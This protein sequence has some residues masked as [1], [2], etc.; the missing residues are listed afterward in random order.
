MKKDIAIGRDLWLVEGSIRWAIY[1]LNTGLIIQITADA[2]LFLS[3][4]IDAKGSF[5]EKREFIKNVSD[6]QAVNAIFKNVE[7]IQ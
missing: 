5:E 1:D 4:L 7:V 3:E 2:G 6:Y